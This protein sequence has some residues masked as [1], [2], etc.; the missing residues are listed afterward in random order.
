[1]DDPAVLEARFRARFEQSRLPQAECDG[2][3]CLILANNALCALVGRSR[4]ELI[5]RPVAALNHPEDAGTADRQLGELLSGRREAAQYER[6]LRGPDA[7]AVPVFVDVTLLRDA[8]GRPAGAAWYYQD[9]RALRE[10][11]RQRH[12]QQELY[13]AFE[14]LARELALVADQEGILL[15]VSPAVSSLLGYAV[16]EVITREGLDFVHPDDE[17]H[18]R[19]EF[20]RVLVE[21][22]TRNW[23]L[24]LRTAAGDW[25]WIEQSAMN[26]LDSSIGGIVSTVRDVTER[27]EAEEALRESELRYRMI[28]ETAQ[29][30]IWAVADDGSTVF[31]NARTAA[32]LGVSLAELYERSPLTFF[33]PG[34]A[35]DLAF[36][37][38]TRAQRGPERY[39]LTY[40]HP[41]GTERVLSVSAAPLP[42]PDSKPGSLAMVSD[43]TDLRRYERE[44]A[45]AAL[46]DGL[47]GL[48]NRALLTDRLEMALV[49]APGCTALLAVTVDRRHLVNQSYGHRVGDTLLAQVAERLVEVVGRGD[50]V[51][52]IGGDTF[53]MV[54]EVTDESHAVERG[55]EFLAALARP[56]EVEGAVLHVTASVGVAL[57]T[58]HTSTDDL[59]RHAD[60]ARHAARTAGGNR[61][62]LFDEALAEQVAQRLSLA[63]ELRKAVAQDELTLQHQPI[64][65]LRTGR[66]V[67]VEALVRWDHPG[68]GAIPP[69]QMLSVAL[70]TG[71]T[72]QLDTW[73][74]QRALAEHGR[75]RAGGRIP[76]DAHL[77]VNLAAVSLTE[78]ALDR[79]LVG[80]AAAHGVPVQ[81]LVLEITETAVLEDGLSGKSVLRRLRE[82]GIGIALDD[83]GT[84]QGSLSFLRDLPVTALKIDT[85]FVRDVCSDGDAL[86]IV[87]SI[88][89]LA[90]AVG[91][92]AVA[93]GV[94]SVEQVAVLRRLGCALAQ[95]R[96][97]SPPVPASEVELSGAWMQPFETARLA[98]APASARG[99][100]PVEPPVEPEHGLHRLLALHRESASLATIAA[101]L[102]SEGFRTPGGSRWHR[103]SVARVIADAAYPSLSPPS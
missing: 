71:L 100:P 63:T 27:V 42:T 20:E 51:G 35:D 89:D 70:L 26:L 69:E 101:A 14:R 45:E 61:V 10:A 76:P 73:V 90:H 99:G 25:R 55:R 41:D 48:P 33:P 30:G 92:T 72:P 56:F 65:D 82:Q 21:G 53:A 60:I 102:N 1:V 13:D 2:D 38:R 85:S 49:R 46:R 64:V 9:L 91:I 5:G 54:C 75:L 103:T 95:G 32:I 22:G 57:A 47:T 81:Q 58:A 97:W 37:L 80:W 79:E 24:R 34:I 7:T 12:R 94:E 98:S 8:E 83:F 66:V 84:A 74:L 28:A 17:D 50:T 31:A 15:Y 86:A 59:L 16:D 88:V 67:G 19:R 11:E 6:V 3:G 96:L 23:T 87:A 78:L 77:A 62:H 44:L 68:R 39:E 4:E 52:R 36:R 43:V 93:E 40:P 18:A 29:E